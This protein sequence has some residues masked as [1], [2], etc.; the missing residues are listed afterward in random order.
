MVKNEY[1]KG[2]KKSSKE[3]EDMYTV[4]Y[5]RDDPLKI[6]IISVLIFLPFLFAFFTGFCSALPNG[7]ETAITTRPT[8]AYLS[9][10][11][12]YGDKIVWEDVRDSA[13]NQIY[14]YDLGSGQEYPINSSSNFQ[15]N[16]AIF[17]D[18]VVWAEPDPLGSD[19]KI[20]VY[21]TTSLIRK[22]YDGYYD[23]MNY[24]FNFPKISGDTIVW[25]DYNVTTSNWDI[26]VVRNSGSLPEL[27]IY[28][29]GDQKHP[30]IYQNTIVYENWTG[31]A[32]NSASDIW[33]YNLSN[34]T[35][36]PV[37]E[38][39]YQETF[40]HISGE[41][42][43]WEATNLTGDGTHIYLFDRGAISRLN[44]FPFDQLHPAIF[45]NRVVVEDY[46]RSAI[47]DIY[48]Y[49]LQTG[50]ETWVAPNNLS[51]S[52]MN[53]DISGTRIVWADSRAGQSDQDIFLFTLGS[54]VV[55]PSAS[56]SANP[57]S[58]SPGLLVTFTDTSQGSPILHRTWNFSDG[59][60][61][62]LN[63]L[64]P[65]MHQFA[66][67]GIYPVK[68]TVGNTLCRNSTP[69]ICRYKIYIDA[70]PE[71]DFSAAL[72]YG[73]TPLTVNFTDTS[74]GAPKSWAWD[75]GDGTTSTE[76]NPVHVYTRPGSSYSVSLTVNNTFG[77]G[78]PD[79]KTQTDYIRTL[80]GATGI[81]LLPVNGITTDQRYHTSF[82]VY[83]GSLLNSYQADTG[84][85]FLTSEPPEEYGWQNIFFVTSD[86][87]GFKELANR[88]IIGNFS[89][90]YFQT[91]DLTATNTTHQIGVNYKFRSTNYPQQSTVA[92]QIWEGGIPSDIALFEYF[93]SLVPPTGYTT[94]SAIPFTAHIAA[95]PTFGQETATIN[96]SIS[97]SWY[98][99]LQETP[100]TPVI[101]IGIG[102]DSAGNTVGIGLRPTRNRAGNMDYFT[103][104]VP[105][106]ITKFGLAQTSGSGNIVQ[107][108]TL[109][110]APHI[111][112]GG[113]SGSDSGSDTGTGSGTVPAAIK[114]TRAPEIK[115]TLV[116]DTG[117][118]A[119]LYSNTKGVI[120]QAT[121]LQSADGLAIVSVG[122][123][124]VATN[125]TGA[126]L[127]SITI[128]SIPDESV[129]GIPDG[130]AF[131]YA[132]M[133][134]DLQPDG[135]TFSPAV[136][137]NFTIPQARWGHDF[138]V[139]TYDEMNS[140]WLD[141]P[142]GYNP[143][144][145]IVTAQLSHF[146]TV[147]L[148]AEAVTQ[149]PSPVRTTIPTPS[150]TISPP[151]PTAVS[152]FS[153][154]LVW[155]SEIVMNNPL[156]FAGLVILVVAIFLYGRKRRRDRIM[157]LL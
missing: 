3:A 132:G 115:P 16:P 51:G 61:V 142:A 14:L 80:I 89:T 6:R 118:T 30:E 42:I 41:K 47:P 157:Y 46:R 63:P 37:S 135:S 136:S 65:V 40:P 126:S 27:V 86:A 38:G 68:L 137:L 156:P 66:S 82:L 128:K 100:T 17:G 13:I 133:A 43:V 72:V 90:V 116:P 112:P 110:I 49:D 92:S 73:F 52:Q 5:K 74:C 77:G 125:S 124:I 113:G 147:A 34:N 35:A 140:V 54:P 15:Y 64:V 78:A 67:A 108:I 19:S 95:D 62:S 85:S 152:V 12:I 50:T 31:S 23:S 121:T 149:A 117:K 7:T 33:L 44:D 81:S 8:C 4:I 60:P 71:A 150:S 99:S 123:G 138:M 87:T 59:S 10:P 22:E 55:C 94:I 11:A 57:P 88:T 122:Q 75:F 153:G 53:P 39:F 20:V 139:K 26:S 143:D 2:V 32:Y 109:T 84:W 114:D 146:C 131:T 76:Q 104:E 134:Y 18:I 9:A 151:A 148:F 29:D 91:R 28:G 129:P 107:L 111:G 127:S 106:Y 103:A 120:T 69:D 93:A 154:M 56:F 83:N 155:V 144:T 70:P 141:V 102:T 36:V 48:L 24:E 130:S 105:P 45:D 96:M 101:I 79:T 98:D 21:D 58:G 25:Q 119:K 1:T 145:G 97:S